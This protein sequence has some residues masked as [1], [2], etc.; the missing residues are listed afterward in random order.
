M[1]AALKMVRTQ[2]IQVTFSS[3]TAVASKS[4]VVLGPSDFLIRD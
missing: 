3:I 2:L 1:G 4:G